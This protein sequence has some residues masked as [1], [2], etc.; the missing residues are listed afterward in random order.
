MRWG[1]P[2]P[3]QKIFF[4]TLS[5][6]PLSCLTAN[7]ACQNSNRAICFSYI[8]WAK[9]N[10][11]VLKVP[12]GQSLWNVCSHLFPYRFL[13]VLCWHLSIYHAVVSNQ[14]PKVHH[15]IS[16][17]SWPKSLPN[18]NLIPVAQNSNAKSQLLTSSTFSTNSGTISNSSSKVVH[19][20]RKHNINWIWRA[21]CAPS[22]F[23]ARHQQTADQ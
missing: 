12:Y 9:N 20:P 14:S 7:F 4:A 17:I 16:Q 1:P 22:F 19:F 8:F 6:S 13:C 15:F 23:Y 21:I 2:A 11:L 10:K 18:A 5:L 3:V